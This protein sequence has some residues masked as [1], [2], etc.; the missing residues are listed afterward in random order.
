MPRAAWLPLLLLFTADLATG[1]SLQAG[2]HPEGNA[3]FVTDGLRTLDEGTLLAPA[4]AG[5]AAAADHTFT[6]TLADHPL[7]DRSSVRLVYAVDGQDPRNGLQAPMPYAG[8]TG[9]GDLRFSAVLRPADLQGPS[10]SAES[11]VRFLIRYTVATERTDAG[12]DGEGYHY[13]RDSE[14]PRAVALTLDGLDAKAAAPG[15]SPA[16]RVQ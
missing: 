16:V 1:T 10:G 5:L 6:V 4:P 13:V 2:P 12:P 11:V 8:T 14:G 7:L 9:L 3:H 15:S